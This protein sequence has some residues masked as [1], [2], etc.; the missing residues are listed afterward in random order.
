LVARKQGFYVFPTARCGHV[1]R[2]TCLR[3]SIKTGRLDCNLAGRGGDG[4]SE[5]WTAVSRARGVQAGVPGQ[6]WNGR[7]SLGDAQA[8]DDCVLDCEAVG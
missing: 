4:S 5:Y 3:A 6:R 8:D 2:S 7:R 1:E